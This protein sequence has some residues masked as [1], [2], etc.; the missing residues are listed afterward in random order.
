M[1]TNILEGLGWNEYFQHHFELNYVKD[2]IPGRV[3]TEQRG[4]YGISSDLGVLQAEV[5]GK[6][7]TH[8]ESAGRFPAIGDWVIICPLHGEDRGIIHY[9]LPERSRFSRQAPG[10][11]TR[12]QIVAA[13]I[14]TVFI[15]GAMDGGRSANIHRLERYL[16]LGWNSG[17][18]PVVLLNKADLCPDIPGFLHSLEPVTAGVDVYPVSAKESS[19]LEALKPYLRQGKTV[20]FLGSSGVGKSALI[21]ALLGYDRQEVGEI[22]ERDFTGRHTTTTRE[23]I[24]LPDGGA[25]IDTPGMREIQMWAGDDGLNSSF[26]DIAILAQQCRFKD[27]QHHAEPGCAVKAAME[28]GELDPQRLDSYEKLQKEIHYHEARQAG[29]VRLEEKLRWKNISKIQ[30]SLKKK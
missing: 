3:V 13:N 28:N 14:D 18:I 21:N 8:A 25:V 22:R 11:R 15:V 7:R 27:C 24:I 1:P 6:L 12:E 23:L 19:G 9:V 26:N 10:G 4:V 29:S 16:T 5:S 2:A 20:A 17:A 30:K